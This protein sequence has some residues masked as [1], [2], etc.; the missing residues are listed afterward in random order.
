MQK[1]PVFILVFILFATST[2]AQSRKKSKDKNIYATTSINYYPALEPYAFFG[3]F[4]LENDQLILNFLTANSGTFI[5]QSGQPLGVE[6]EHFNDFPSRFLGI[7]GSVQMVKG[8]GL[9]H[10]I[11]LT[12]LSVEKSSF[13]INFIFRDSLENLRRFVQGYEQKV[14]SFSFRYEFGK[15]FGRRKGAKV[16]FGLA[17]AFEPSLY[18]YKRTP[19]F[20]QEYPVEA[21][22][23]ALEM[24]VIPS[25]SAKLSKYVSLDFKLIPNF[26]IADFG[27]IAERNPAHT[28]KQQESGER[29]YNLP[30]IN[31]GF[32]VAVK[33]LVKE[34]KR[35]GRR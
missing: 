17:G 31:L 30:E 22:I 20:S 16:R 24:A 13:Q 1:M 26:L 14:S 4:T 10:E 6:R 28:K 5:V 8:D 2:F 7:G 15:Y 29:E 18:F 34:A 9:Y 35:R 33:Y 21:S 11:S 27:T 23:F 12:K 19:K 32:S 3:G 25:L